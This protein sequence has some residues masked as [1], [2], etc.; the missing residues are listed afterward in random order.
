MASI[1]EL[2]SRQ[3]VLDATVEFDRLGRDAFLETYG[4]GR[5]RG[6]FLLVEGRRYDSK[7]V[8]GRAYGYQYPESGPLRAKDFSGGQ[9][10]VSAKLEELG[11]EVER[12]GPPTRPGKGGGF[13]SEGEAAGR[14]GDL[15]GLSVGDLFASQTALFKSGFHRMNQAGIC[16]RAKEGAESIVVSGGYADDLDFGNEI[17]YTGEG[18][19]DPGVTR[20]VRDQ[21]FARRNAALARSQATGIPVRVFRG[22]GGDPV[23]SPEAGLRYDG[24]FRVTEHW[25]ETGRDGFLIWRFRLNALE[26]SEGQARDEVAVGSGGPAPRRHV[27]SSMLVRDRLIAEQVKRLH[28][29]RCQ[30]CGTR[31]ELASGPYAE[32]AHII[33][34]GAPHN[35]PD[36]LSNLLCLCPNCHV[37]FDHGA[38]SVAEDLSLIGIEGRLRTVPRHGIDDGALEHH[39]SRW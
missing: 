27:M 2:T 18:G 16:G 14:F 5:A 21:E 31:I 30:F 19:R 12:G 3:A 7:A 32:A 35:G 10:T 20:H 33:P 6:Y 17:I 34:L 39:R 1:S 11:F 9:A 23:F 22:A 36:R 24:L 28:R 15:P 37:M 29:Y 13:G 38:V 4:F 8:V 25:S 26:P